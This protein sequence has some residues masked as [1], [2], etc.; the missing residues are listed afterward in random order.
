LSAALTLRSER[1]DD[2]EQADMADR[3]QIRGKRVLVVEDDRDTAELFGELVEVLGAVAAVAHDGAEA[4]RLAATFRPDVVL[5][6][7]GLPGM[8]GYEV[9]MR[10]RE[11]SSAGARVRI[12]AVSGYGPYDHPE[13]AAGVELA[14]FLLKPFTVEELLGAIKGSPAK[15]E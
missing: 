2:G 3:E 9:A 8:D 10:L 11:A 5:L 6:D 15:R 4:L 13:R 14:G 7:I 12:V 1:Y